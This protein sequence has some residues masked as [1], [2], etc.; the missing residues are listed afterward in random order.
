MLE[1]LQ[2]EPTVERRSWKTDSCLHTR[3]HST[4]NYWPTK[5][6][7]LFELIFKR[8]SITLPI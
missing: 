4:A 5:I 8:F 6:S 7:Q 2:P 3:Q 1:K